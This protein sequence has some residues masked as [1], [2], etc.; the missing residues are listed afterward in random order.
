MKNAYTIIALTPEQITQNPFVDTDGK[1]RFYR[2][3]AD[4]FG[5]DWNS[6]NFGMDCRKINVATNIQDSWYKYAEVNG[7][8]EEAL[9]TCILMSGP[10]AIDTLGD[11]I[12][13][14]EGGA[15]TY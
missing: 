15:I 11:N 13:E 12:V 5:Y 6:D 4:I 10:K 1:A 8:N 7:I 2:M 9:T 3:I 14:I